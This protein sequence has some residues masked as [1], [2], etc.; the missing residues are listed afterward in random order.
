MANPIYDARVRLERYWH[1]DGLAEI[2]GG[3]ANILVGGSLS[4]SAVNDGQSRLPLAAA[5]ACVL[6]LLVFNL[7]QQRIVRSIRERITYPSIGYVGPVEGGTTRAAGI[8]VLVAL[9]SIVAGALV[10]RLAGGLRGPES[11]GWLRFSPAVLGLVFG[12]VCVFYGVRLRLPRLL[13]VGAIAILVGLIATLTSSPRWGLCT[14]FISVGVAML[15]SGGTA[16]RRL[17]RSGYGQRA[18]E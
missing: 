16:L 9:A 1:L 13:L 12:A 10:F 11:L 6:L 15:V 14:Y 2:S 3:I 4:A 17:V 5:A 7:V 8:A 18:Q